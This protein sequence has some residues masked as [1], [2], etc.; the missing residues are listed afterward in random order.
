MRSQVNFCEKRNT[1]FVYFYVLV[2]GWEREVLHD[3]IL[4]KWRSLIYNIEIFRNEY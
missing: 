2:Y 3:E 4:A 1:V